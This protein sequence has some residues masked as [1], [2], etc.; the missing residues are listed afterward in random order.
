MQE[1]I[2][3]A[4]LGRLPI[5]LQYVRSIDSDTISATKI[6][7][8]LNL[9]EVQVRKDLGAVCGNGR[10]KVGYERTT[11]IKDLEN[12]L[13]V[14]ECTEAIIIGAGKLGLALLGYRGFE[15]YGLKVRAAFDIAADKTADV[16]GERFI[17]PMDECKEYCKVNNIRIAI[18]TVPASAAQQACDDLVS[19][20]IT[21]I[22]NFAPCKLKTREGITVRQENLALS[23]A[24]LNLMTVNSTIQEEEQ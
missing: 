19:C 16:G 18:L 12:A 6:A 13:G 7:G 10:P 14:Y 1:Y 8:A 15:E 5:Y 23:L 17:K 11:L 4:T 2:T 22:L 21:A 24:H 3:R 9:G 20:G